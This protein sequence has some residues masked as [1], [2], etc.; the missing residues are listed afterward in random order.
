MNWTKIQYVAILHPKTHWLLAWINVAFYFPLK[1]QI[2]FF[3]CQVAS[4][5]FFSIFRS[6]LF[7]L[8]QSSNLNFSC[9]YGLPLRNHVYLMIIGLKSGLAITNLQ[10]NVQS[11]EQ[12]MLFKEQVTAFLKSQTSSN[13]L[14]LAGC[15]SN[16]SHSH[17]FRNLWSPKLCHLFR[18]MT[19]RMFRHSLE[20]WATIRNI[21]LHLYV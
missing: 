5:S 3:R 8:V 11:M 14:C 13:Y 15:R 18:K 16:Q 2:S 20:S 17:L 6:W 12:E 21:G 19:G 7:R 4:T 10:T 1:V 9:C